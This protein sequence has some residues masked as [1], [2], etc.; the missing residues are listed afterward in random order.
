M[1]FQ[2]FLYTWSVFV[3]LHTNFK[4]YSVLCM[5]LLITLGIPDLLKK[6]RMSLYN[7]A[8]FFKESIFYICCALLRLC[9]I[10]YSGA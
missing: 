3:N 7:N 4:V 2:G 9:I 6:L 1:I 5:G 8:C 10:N